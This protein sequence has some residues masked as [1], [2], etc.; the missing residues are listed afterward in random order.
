MPHVLIIDDDPEMALIARK[1]LHE[2]DCK[3]DV[4]NDGDYAVRDAIQIA[5]DVILMD[6]HMPKLNGVTAAIELR[7]CEA[8]REIPVILS[9][10]NLMNRRRAE[11]EGI[12]HFIDKPY[13]RDGLV[14]LV[15]AL[16]EFRGA[17]V[18]ASGGC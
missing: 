3:V 2:A 7:N 17:T 14:G 18:Q 1:F 8:T 15:R 5:P 16:A 10:A 12:H 11:E 13:D 9:S 6:V 4:V